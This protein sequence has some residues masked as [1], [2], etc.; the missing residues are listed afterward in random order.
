MN[1]DGVILGSGVL[2]GMPSGG[3]GC[4][5]LERSDDRG[6]RRPRIRRLSAHKKRSVTRVGGRRP[7][8]DADAV[9]V[10]VIVVLRRSLGCCDL[11]A[12]GTSLEIG[13]SVVRQFSR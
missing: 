7:L 8:V 1:K 5:S 2:R 13:Q 4:C 12:S 9:E 11:L 10:E 3:S 6:R